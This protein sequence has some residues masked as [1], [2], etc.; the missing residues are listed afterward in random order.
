MKCDVCKNDLCSC[1][2][3]KKIINIK[4]NFANKDRLVNLFI[5]S[6]NHTKLKP[7]PNNSLIIGPKPIIQ[8]PKNTSNIKNK[9]KRNHAHNFD[10]KDTI[11]NYSTINRVETK[12]VNRTPREFI[13]R[14]KSIVHTPKN[15]YIEPI[16]HNLKTKSI[17]P[18]YKGNILL[19]KFIQYSEKI[20]NIIRVN[21]FNTNPL[22]LYSNHKI[23]KNNPFNLQT[24]LY[25]N[26]S[27]KSEINTLFKNENLIT[28]GFEYEF[29]GF[30]KQ[31]FLSMNKEAQY[32]CAT[33]HNEI[34]KDSTNFINEW[35]IETDA[36]K[37]LELVSPILCLYTSNKYDFT[38]KIIAAFT[39]L[40]FYTKE[41][42]D[43]AKDSKNLNI[44]SKEINKKYNINIEKIESEHNETGL[45]NLINTNYQIEHKYQGQINNKIRGSHL[46]IGITF[47]YLINNLLEKDS[48][49]SFFITICKK[50]GQNT[51]PNTKDWFYINSN[52][53]SQK[54]SIIY[55]SLRFILNK[56]LKGVNINTTICSALLTL[57]I[58]E[59]TS[60]IE[61]LLYNYLHHIERDSNLQEIYKKSHRRL[62]SIKSNSFD[63]F[64][65]KTG[66]EGIIACICL[67]VPANYRSRLC[68]EIQ[69]TIESHKDNIL[70]YLMEQICKTYNIDKSSS[71]INKCSKLF[72]PLDKYISCIMNR[73]L[74]NIGRIKGLT[75]N[76]H[77]EEE[78]IYEINNTLKSA[79]E[80]RISTVA[81]DIF[82]FNNLDIGKNLYSSPEKI[83]TD[84]SKYNNLAFKKM[85]EKYKSDFKQYI[86]KSKNISELIE[87]YDIAGL[88]G[89]RNETYL[90]IR[91]MQ[92][93]IP[94]VV[95]EFRNP[96]HNIEFFIKKIQQLNT[97]KKSKEKR[98]HYAKTPESRL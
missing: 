10:V 62:T 73:M 27:L 77:K 59:I 13:I 92:N 21:N 32:L 64:W 54:L 9:H 95:I 94:E 89:A 11:N 4:H 81:N 80:L 60:Y 40:E 72:F 88:T 55:T 61:K 29:A 7:I 47:D 70:E 76:S 43:I 2:I 23:F 51:T 28:F 52:L 67:Y 48:N 41:I 79:I 63:K 42:L 65:I 26:K 19:N 1:H 83:I 53:I 17:T 56:Y 20:L 86:E 84:I 24:L 5:N 38:Q 97:T 14:D 3:K 66:L 22:Q 82:T 30:N 98:K 85:D 75:I 12:S 6:Q 36:Q 33:G 78:I 8:L 18:R 68:T 45:L 25:Y 71:H 49:F 31:Q 44:F 90:P 58:I 91:M 74:S 57:K 50:N 96:S 69:T 39:F 46:N 87:A 93:N 35:K 37:E 15:N 16:I 34:M